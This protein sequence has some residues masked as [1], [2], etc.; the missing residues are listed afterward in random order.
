MM[1]KINVAEIV[2]NSKINSFH[3]SVLLWCAFIIIFDGFDLVVFGTVVPTLSELWSLQPSTIGMIGSLALFG[4]LI[5]A[6]LSGMLADKLGRKNLIIANVILFSIF[7][8]LTGFATGPVQFA[9][10]R[11]IAGL[12]LGGVAPLVVT[13]TSEYSPK[14]IR[15]LMVGIM[16][17]GYPLGAILVSITG[18]N[19]IPNLG[20]E[21]MFYIGALPLLSIPFLIKFMPESIS[22]YVAKGNYTKV[23][24]I[25]QKVEPGFVPQPG[26]VFE[27]NIP[28]TGM[29]VVKLFEEKRGIST[30]SFS[31][32][33]LIAFL[34]IY[35]LGTWL[36][37]IM[38]SAGYELKSSLMFLLTL[39]IGG[40]I[41]AIFGGWLADKVGSKK[42]LI[43]IFLL[44]GLSLTL[45]GFS[46]NTLLLYLFIGIGGLASTGAQIILN[47]YT[48]KFYPIHI[49]STA[50]GF[51]TGFGRMGA[52]LGPTLLGFLLELKL[53]PQFNFIAL[54]IPIFIG[55]LT[56]SFV[57]DKYSD[58]GK[59]SS[60]SIKKPSSIDVEYKTTT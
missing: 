48:S 12:G 29:P 37:Q 31:L 44:G 20:W 22:Y 3:I 51:T 60:V 50:I 26:D 35:S 16:F 41:G 14:K 46:T 33:C 39:N 2:D 21:W 13:L 43:T 19:V 8:L 52:I 55:A 57:I 56:I 15:S 53:D 38:V 34:V 27:T 1:R 7:T 49:R 25:L 36:P 30:I 6:P 28:K 54:G 32:T 10:F 59:E 24:A 23:N 11:F 45:L 9:I 17:S 40:I 5:G 18:M 4:G 42:V 58:F 47:G